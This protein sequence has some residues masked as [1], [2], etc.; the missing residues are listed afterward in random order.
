MK[1]SDTDSLTTWNARWFQANANSGALTGEIP[2]E[3]VIPAVHMDG[4]DSARWTGC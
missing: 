3:P 2:Q 1:I 4:M